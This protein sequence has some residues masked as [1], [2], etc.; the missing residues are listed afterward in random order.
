MK[1]L[2]FLL[3]ILAGSCQ[4]II[5]EEPNYYDARDNL[6]GRYQVD[7]FSESTE[8][9]FSYS[10]DIYKSCCNSNEVVIYN[11]YDV[12]LEVSAQFDGY[13]L[14]IPSQY[15]GDYKVEGTGRLENGELTVSYVVHNRFQNP[16]TDF[17]YFTSWLN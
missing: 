4:L 8:Q 7:E 12:D 17:L 13:K 3:L 15:I 11:F 1:K 16:S 5:N 9:Y 2:S 10:I 6:V 14:I